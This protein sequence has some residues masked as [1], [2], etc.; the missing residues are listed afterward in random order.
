M[1]TTLVLGKINDL[2]SSIS[3]GYID[4]RTV[5]LKGYESE[6]DLTF[7]LTIEGSDKAIDKLLKSIKV[8]KLDDLCEMFLKRASQ[9]QLDEHIPTDEEED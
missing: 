4:K 7:N 2:K 1:M 6:G 8:K 3:G 9:T 5:K